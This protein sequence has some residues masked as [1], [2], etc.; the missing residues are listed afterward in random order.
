MFLA[1]IR[2]NPEAACNGAVGRLHLHS[3][4]L[5]THGFAVEIHA[6]R[7]LELLAAVS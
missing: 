3:L 2:C 1:L 7:I 4:V 5:D 6:K